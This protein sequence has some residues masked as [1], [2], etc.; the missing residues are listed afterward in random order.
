V[1][2]LGGLRPSKYENRSSFLLAYDSAGMA[3]DCGQQRGD[4][5]REREQSEDVQ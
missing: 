5:K 1:P 2:D 3:G 4:K